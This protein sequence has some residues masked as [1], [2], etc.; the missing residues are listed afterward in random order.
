MLYFGILLPLCSYGSLTFDVF[1]FAILNP[2]IG[3]F[4]VSFTLG[5]ILAFVSEVIVTTIVRL[6]VFKIWEPSIFKL[7]PEVPSLILP[8]VLRE[9]QYKPKRITLFAADFGASCIASPIIEECLKLMV[10]QWTC[11]LPR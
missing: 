1:E 10:V 3:T 2:K 5:Y 7:T 8:W 4:H 11:R 9:K 6:G